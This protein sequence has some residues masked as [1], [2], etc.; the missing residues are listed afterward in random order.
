MAG[1]KRHS[2]VE[3][4]G[5]GDGAGGGGAV[6]GGAAGGGGG[7]GGTAIGLTLSSFSK[8]QGN[9]ACQS[10]AEMIAMTCT[11]RN[12]EVRLAVQASAFT[13][14][15]QQI[16][17][18]GFLCKVEVQPDCAIHIHLPAL[19]AQNVLFWGV[20]RVVRHVQGVIWLLPCEGYKGAIAAIAEALA[21]CPIH[22]QAIASV[23]QLFRQ[24]GTPKCFLQNDHCVNVIM[25]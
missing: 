12:E 23:C 9:S 5:G 20:A 25:K 19:R 13:W 3:A 4:S 14:Q 24:L 6:L 18:F 16:L 2:L 21:H 17:H 7:N 8:L 10:G 15:L 22:C 1:Q 11:G